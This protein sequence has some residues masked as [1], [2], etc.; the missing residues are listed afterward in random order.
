MARLPNYDKEFKK[1]I[2]TNL[3]E[4]IQLLGERED[5]MQKK[6]A[7]FSTNF[8]FKSKDV[9]AKIKKDRMFRAHFAKDPGRQNLYEKL[10][11]QYIKSIKGVK[12]FEKLGSNLKVILNGAVMTR[13]QLRQLGGVDEAKTID[14]EWYYHKHH[15]FAS[16]KYTK[17]EGGGQGN[18]YK[19]VQIFI[20]QATPSTLKDTF[21]I[22]ICDGNFYDCKDTVTNTSRLERLKNM[23]NNKNV[24]AMKLTELKD[25]LE[26]NFSS[27]Q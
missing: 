9:E 2:K 14:F 1:K 21:F 18:Q 25:W 5:G 26:K 20:K 10:A 19:D 23:A 4:V 6:V 17:G 22:A 11:G 27:K 24:F 7:T 12:N 15:F 8:D 13:A 3:D 16:H